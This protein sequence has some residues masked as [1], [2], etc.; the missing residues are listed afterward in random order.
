MAMNSNCNSAFTSKN[1]VFEAEKK[2]CQENQKPKVR[3]LEDK[4]DAKLNAKY[5]EFYE[6]KHVVNTINKQKQLQ[7]QEQRHNSILRVQEHYRELLDQ[8]L[9]EQQNHYLQ[10][11]QQL[12]QQFT[13]E[14]TAPTA[15]Q[16]CPRKL[17]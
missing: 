3:Q 5:D 8:R 16:R 6:L 17:K 1:S 7:Q 11:E 10:E 4:L 2:R 15:S 9:A 13:A 12:Q 14:A